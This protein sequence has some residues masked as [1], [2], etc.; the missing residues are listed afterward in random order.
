M[1]QKSELSNSGVF[2]IRCICNDKFYIASAINIRKRFNSDK[3]MLKGGNH[4]NPRLQNDWNKFGGEN[5][6]FGIFEFCNMEYCDEIKSKY[7][8]KY[9][10]QMYLLGKSNDTYFMNFS[11][12]PGVY[13][14]ENVI[15]NQKYIGS[16]LNV[17]RRFRMHHKMLR[18]NSHFN[19]N[20]QDSWN[21]NGIK[22]FEFALIENCKEEFLK[23]REQYYIDFYQVCKLGFNIAPLS[24]STKGVVK[25]EEQRQKIS[26]ATKQAMATEKVK[27]NVSKAQKLRF[28]NPEEKI[29]MRNIINPIL[30][31][32]KCRSENSKR[33]KSFW[34]NEEFVKKQKETRAKTF[35]KPEV[36]AKMKEIS[37][38]MWSDP[39]KYKATLEKRSNVTKE[40]VAR[41]LSLKDSGLSYRQIAEKVG[42][43]RQIAGRICRGENKFASL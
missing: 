34:Q 1:R 36:R 6:E 38:N 30:R 24:H 15:T 17:R 9:K 13:M 20:L 14:I 26:I 25:T 12:M 40:Q 43:N 10:E 16:S 4:Y 21:K 8:E 2:F 28:S 27:N 7:I 42:C 19:S 18:A 3:S 31:S 22:N 33:L 11:T 32:E 41:I 35:S 29:R 37:I 5:F 39:E 23:E